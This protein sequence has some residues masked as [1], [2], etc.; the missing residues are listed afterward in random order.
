MLTPEQE[1]QRQ[2]I[3]DAV[4]YIMV[5]RIKG[6]LVVAFPG[7]G[8]VGGQGKF[9]HYFNIGKGQTSLQDMEAL[10]SMK[11]NITNKEAARKLKSIASETS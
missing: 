6:N 7:N 9:E 1:M 2:Q 3:D 10:S 5:N 8:Y 11:K 4:R